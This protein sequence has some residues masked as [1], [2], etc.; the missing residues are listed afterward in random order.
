MKRRISLG[1][2]KGGDRDISGFDIVLVI[3]AK[4]ASGFE[5]RKR[6]GKAKSEFSTYFQYIKWTCL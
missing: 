6:I 4:L 3:I 1:V 2:D 5:G